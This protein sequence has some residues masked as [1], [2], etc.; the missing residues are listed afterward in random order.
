MLKRNFV[1]FLVLFLIFVPIVSFAE[2]SLSITRWKI[3]STLLDN[4]DL[5]ISED[6]TFNYND[7]FNGVYRSIVLKGTDG[8]DGL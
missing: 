5:S 7:T 4:G 2:D 6:I 1:L 3:D 8:V